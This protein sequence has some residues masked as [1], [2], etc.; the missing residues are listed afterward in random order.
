MSRR[1]N[2]RLLPHSRMLRGFRLSVA[3]LCVFSLSSPV[4]SGDDP[5]TAAT[6]VD[7]EGSTG[8]APEWLRTGVPSWGL[9]V[10]PIDLD[11][12]SLELAVADN[13]LAS[14]A[15]RA[16]AG[17]TWQAP[18]PVSPACHVNVLSDHDCDV[19]GRLPAYREAGLLALSALP[20]YSDSSDRKLAW[21]LQSEDLPYIIRIAGR[22]VELFWPDR[23][24]SIRQTPTRMTNIS[25]PST[26]L[27]YVLG[28]CL[29]GGLASSSDLR[30]VQDGY[31]FGQALL[32]SL[33]TAS[34]AAP[35]DPVAP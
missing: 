12:A 10:P 30:R 18:L 32:I 7:L 24:A 23:V 33:P 22:N 19:Y 29:R 13:E 4:R 3:F 34:A 17:T 35:Q 15:L 28:N 2:F 26:V 25:E 6:T 27:L 16:L 14:A 21:C 5:T 1:A 11:S 8:Y 9:T 31:T 20:S